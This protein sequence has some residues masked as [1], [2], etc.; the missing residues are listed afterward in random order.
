MEIFGKMKINKKFNSRCNL[1]FKTFYPNSISRY[2][3]VFYWHFISLSRLHLR[4]DKSIPVFGVEIQTAKGTLKK[5]HFFV[6]NV[7]PPLTPPLV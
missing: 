7:K 2:F 4:L 6:T 1:E 3:F 5:N